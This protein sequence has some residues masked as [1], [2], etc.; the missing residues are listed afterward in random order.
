MYS[1][2]IS[3]ELPEIMTYIFYVFCQFVQATTV[4]TFMKTLWYRALCENLV[5]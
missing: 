5:K 1:V 4:T 3:T 2:Q